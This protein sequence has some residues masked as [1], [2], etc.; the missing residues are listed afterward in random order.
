MASSGSCLLSATPCH[1]ASTQF[2]PSPVMKMGVKTKKSDDIDEA[3]V[4]Q[5]SAKWT[6][7]GMGSSSCAI[8][9]R[10]QSLNSNSR[11]RSVRVRA[12]P[13]PAHV[14]GSWA[15]LTDHLS[16]LTPKCFKPGCHACQGGAQVAADRPRVTGASQQPVAVSPQSSP[17][18]T[19]QERGMSA[20]IC[21]A[22]LAG[23]RTRQRVASQRYADPG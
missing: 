16:A 4:S 9:S 12:A 18:E 21:R 10:G 13:A 3:P 1:F 19:C 15:A 17:T 23:A 8:L 7:N 6:F 22:S 11:C 5:L 14:G 20:D 2:P